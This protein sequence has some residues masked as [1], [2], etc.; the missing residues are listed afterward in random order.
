MTGVLAEAFAVQGLSRVY[1]AHPGVGRGLPP[2]PRSALLAVAGMHDEVESAIS[3]WWLCDAYLT[4]SATR[5]PILLIADDAQWL[6]QLTYDVLV[7]ISRRLSS[8]PLLSWRPC[9][10]VSIA[11]W[12]RR[13]RSAPTFRLDNADAER[14][15]DNRP[16]P[17]GR[18]ASLLLSE[19]C[20]NP[21]VL[22]ELPRGEAADAPDAPWLPLTRRLECAFS[23]RLS[24][25]EFHPTGVCC[26]GKRWA[27]SHEILRAGEVVLASRWT[28]MHWHQELG[29]VDPD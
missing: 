9:V 15:L 10:T 22:V 21:L 12:G 14:P 2:R 16:R 7:F 5:K 23:S 1:Y 26:S 17:F 20:G 4:E 8:I 29:K 25:H 24:E 3:F 27:F 18:C 11:R 19:A 13:H 28:L 6:D